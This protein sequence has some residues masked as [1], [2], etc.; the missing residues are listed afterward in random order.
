VAVASGGG[1]YT[2]TEVQQNTTVGTAGSIIGG[3]YDAIE[4]QYIGNNTFTV[5]SNEGNLVV[6]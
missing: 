4:L 2:L 3:Q 1:I 6:Q 5:L